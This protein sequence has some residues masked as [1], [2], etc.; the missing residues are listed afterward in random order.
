M[1]TDMMGY[2]PYSKTR[3]FIYNSISDLQQSNVGINYF[4]PVSG[5][6]TQ[7]AKAYSE[8][9][10]P[11]T[12][13]EFKD[14]LLYKVTVLLMNEMLYGGSLKEMLQSTFMHLPEWFTEGAAQ[15]ISRGWSIEMDDFVREYLRTQNNVKLQK[16]LARRDRTSYSIPASLF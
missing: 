4:G 13:L 10:H 5:G 8:I 7:F 15:Y 9:A 1:L 16:L 11:G 3:V 2:P 6:E 14:E 12:V